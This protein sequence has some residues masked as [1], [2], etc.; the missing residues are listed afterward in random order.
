MHVPL[1]QFG[2][3]VQLDQCRGRPRVDLSGADTAS[4]EFGV[5]NFARVSGVAYNGLR[6]RWPQAFGRKRPA[7]N[8]DHPVRERVHAPSSS[9]MA[10]ASS[11]NDVPP[12]DYEL[13]VDRATLP[14]SF[15]APERPIAVRAEAA[16]TVS[17]DIPLR[18][19]R[20]IGGRVYFKPSETALAANAGRAELMPVVGMQLRAGAATAVTG[21]D[22]S[23]LFRDL[24]AGDLE[25]VAEPP[26]PLPADLRRPSGKIRLPVDPIHIDDVT[27]VIS[28][29]ELLAYFVDGVQRL[30]APER[31]HD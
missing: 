29:L 9:P 12:G 26:R 25:L 24:P 27:M 20:S 22:G 5:V 10:A 30:K 1:D 7:R 21:A 18:A 28:N 11:L 2:E 14:P 31:Q 15:A 17:R 8:R 13:I 3:A 6:A 16:T 19:I 4:V 23:F